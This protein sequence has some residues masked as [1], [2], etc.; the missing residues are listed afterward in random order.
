MFK[1]V[2]L[3]VA[4]YDTKKEEMTI[5]PAVICKPKQVKEKYELIL[6]K[7]KIDISDDSDEEE[8]D[9]NN[10]EYI[11]RINEFNLDLI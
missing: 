4:R 6:L 1:C 3:T 8:Y 2:V 9:V 11:Y 10:Y 7:D 5:L